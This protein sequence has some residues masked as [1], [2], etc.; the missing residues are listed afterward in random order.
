MSAD[1]LVFAI[2]KRNYA[3]RYARIQDE[4]STVRV[5]EVT[6]SARAVRL[7]EVLTTI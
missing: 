4:A 6:L 2:A 5:P 1:I 3:T 7:P